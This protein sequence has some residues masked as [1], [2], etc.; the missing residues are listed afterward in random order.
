[1]TF[2]P[3]V[4]RRIRRHRRAREMTQFQCCLAV[5][6]AQSV[7]SVLEKGGL[8]GRL[9]VVQKYCDVIGLDFSLVLA[10]LRRN[11]GALE[12]IF[13]DAELFLGDRSPTRR[14]NPI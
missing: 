13:R 6:V 8:P 1:M 9:S 12:P 10:D 2:V 11:V 14:R 7:L 4:G 3:S 5:G